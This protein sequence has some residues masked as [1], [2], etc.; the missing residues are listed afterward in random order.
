MR[1][2]WVV[3]LLSW[4]A[5]T[6]LSAQ[7]PAPPKASPDP[8]PTADAAYSIDTLRTRVR[9]EDDG[10]GTRELTFAVKVLDEQAVRQWGQ[11]KLPYQSDTEDLDVRSVQVQ[12]PDGS[13]SST[14]A[15]GVQ[16]LSMAPPGSLAIFQDLRQKVITVSALR[17]GDVVKVDV[18]WTT[19]K[20]IAPNQFWFEHSFN[21]T[22]PVR[23]EVLEIDAPAKR[24]IALKTGK[25][26]PAEEHGGAGAAAGERRVYRWKSSHTVDASITPKPRQ[27]DE[28]EP[29]ADVRLSSFQNWDE[30]TAWFGGLASAAPDAAVTAKAAALTS[31]AA[32]EAAKIAA[33][34]RYVSSEIRYV[35]LSFGIGR[36]A[37]HPPAEVLAHQYGDCKDK[38]ILLQALFNAAGVRSAPVLVNTGRSIADDFASPLEF[39]H[40]V[41]VVPGSD[42]AKG[43]WLDPTMEIAPVGMLS[44]PTRDRRALVVESGKRAMIVRTPANHPFP[45]IEDVDLRGT[46]NAIGVLTAKVTYTFRGDTELAV[47]TIVRTAPRSALKAIVT[48]LATQNDLTGDISDASASDPADTSKPFELTFQLRQRGYLDWAAAQSEL[49]GLPTTTFEFTKEEERRDL[50]RLYLGEPKTVR[51]H[52]NIE[53]PPGYDLDPPQP[54]N[55]KKAGL[56]YVA[57]YSVEGRR[58]ILNREVA[59]GVKEVPLS[60]FGEYSALVAMAQADTAQRFK[61]HGHVSAT[62]EVPT[63]ATGDELYKAAYSAYDAKRYD[64]AVALW[65]RNTEVTPKMG[66]VWDA[67]GLAYNQLKKYDEAAAAI[68][69][70]IDLDPYDKRAYGDLGLVLKAAGKRE[71]AAKAYAK[72]VELN[73]LDG[74]GFKELGFLYNDLRKYPEAAAAL[75]KAGGLLPKHA[76]VQAELASAYLQMKDAGRAKA[77]IDRVMQLSPDLEVRTSVAWNLAEA[78]LDVDRAGDL[79]SRALK[80][81]A[82]ENR[83][84]ALASVTETHLDRV[85]T[86]AWLWDTIGWIAFQK[87]DAEKAERYVRAA[88]ELAGDADVAFHLGQI[89]Q[90]R[91]RLADALSYYLTAEALSVA[92]TE[93]MRAH[94]KRLAG[95][96]D[97]PLMIKSAREVAAAG[98]AFKVSGQ[99]AA[100]MAD[101]L[102]IVGSDGRP[103]EVRFAGGSEELREF[104]LAQLKDAV[105]SLDFPGDAPERLPVGL[106]LRCA[107]KLGC[108][109]GLAYPARV[110]LAKPDK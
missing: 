51:L 105:I 17:P 69:K 63:D 74:D 39:D 59:L 33:I 7:M 37:A 24:K 44:G 84:L 22:Q 34:Y 55:A 73:A 85:E 110:E 40:M 13:M 72:H 96:G 99:G 27:M 36:Y 68:Q 10:G 41:L 82:D 19:K 23:E 6:A 35:S 87:G 16:D 49:R 107:A 92:P 98:R 58:L 90:K 93:D 103:I 54:V 48:A 81:I 57:T 62:P 8:A 108:Q 95:G 28:E 60:A 101:F 29:P 3:V 65:K 77:A 66:A 104:G 15:A 80:E 50:D 89:H 109:G 38:A 71:A 9:L 52:A 20:P 31:G 1:K 102:A 88:W 78:G 32:D 43:T 11:L 100:G 97:L 47:R 46:V 2:R 94:V 67:L 56:A 30:F 70:Q 18:L 26:S 25:T 75:E 61:V 79:A 14:D 21:S 12:K 4:Y 76:W 53:L 83:N 5:A 64:A 45:S 91:D 106:R 42:L 86:V